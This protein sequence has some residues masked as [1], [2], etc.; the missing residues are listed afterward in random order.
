MTETAWFSG[1]LDLRV[2]AA[3]EWVLLEPFRY[4]SRD[5]RNIT[6]PPWFITDLASIPWAVQPLF[7]S[8]EHRAAGVVHDWLYCSQLLSRA[9]ADELFCEMVQVLGAGKVRAGLMHAGLRAGGWYRWNQCVGGPK[10]GDFA[11]EFM[12]AAER[13]AYREGYLRAALAAA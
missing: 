4:R 13:A 3:G 2:Y 8:V 5:G 9:E 11:W 12:R 10:E 7:N 1:A 6:V